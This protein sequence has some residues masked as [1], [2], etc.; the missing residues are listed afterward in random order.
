LQDAR[1][2]AR[3]PRRGQQ[4]IRS[5][6]NLSGSPGGAE[7]AARRAEHVLEAARSARRAAKHRDRQSTTR[8]PSDSQHS[9]RVRDG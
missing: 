4:G 2:Q 3:T 9:R 5:H 6:R 1:T 8:Q 7:G